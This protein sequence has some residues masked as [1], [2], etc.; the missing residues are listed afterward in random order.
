MNLLEC[1]LTAAS[2][3]TVGEG[4]TTWAGMTHRIQG[5]YCR[6]AEEETT[7]GNDRFGI[8]YGV[9]RSVTL[10]LLHQFGW[11]RLQYDAKAEEGK[12][13]RLRSIRRLPLGDAMIAATCGIDRLEDD[14]SASLQD[15]LGPFFPQ[16]ERRLDVGETEF[17][18][19][20][21]TL[22]VSLGKVWR[23]IAAPAETSLDEFAY[24]VLNAF[25]FDHDHL[26]QF[27]YRDRRGME[28]HAVAPEIGDGEVFA[29]EVRLGELP[30]S[31]GDTITM[32]YDFGDSWDFRVKLE[33]VGDKPSR[34]KGP[35][36]V[37]QSGTAPEQYAYDDWD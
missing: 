37:K 20:E 36:V 12:T 33:R 1:W 24:D 29:D 21:H 2:L 35:R 8:A 17:R 30:I 32:L 15:V 6:L 27:T 22:K 18:E 16:W 4:R 10:S 7:L 19:G 9:E 31:E 13:A 5:L 34:R 3:A 25:Q 14:D 23:R 11:V 26:Y 28:V